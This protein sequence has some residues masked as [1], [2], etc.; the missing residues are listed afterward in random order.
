MHSA[1]NKTLAALP[2]D[3]VVFV[4]SLFFKTPVNMTQERDEAGGEK[5]G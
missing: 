4:S 3:T 2:D 5:V 1:L